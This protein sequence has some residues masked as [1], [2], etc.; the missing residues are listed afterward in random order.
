MAFTAGPGTARLTAAEVVQSV[1]VMERG[2]TAGVSV[3]D[4]WWYN[5]YVYEAGVVQWKLCSRVGLKPFSHE[6]VNSVLNDISEP[7]GI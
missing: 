6:S 3:S 4:P 5:V 1:T 2:Q 7:E